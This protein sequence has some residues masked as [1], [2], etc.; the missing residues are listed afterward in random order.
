MFVASDG[1]KARLSRHPV[2]ALVTNWVHCTFPR[3][4]G[5]SGGLP[6]QFSIPDQRQFVHDP[7]TGAEATLLEDVVA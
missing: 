3:G 5:E 4:T 6:S 2:L 1:T 7:S